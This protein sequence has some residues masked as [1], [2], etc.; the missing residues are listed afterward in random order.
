MS[1]IADK[2]PAENPPCKV[3]V[4]VKKVM[5]KIVLQPENANPIVKIP[6]PIVPKM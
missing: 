2:G 5:A 3:V 4:I 1:I 6:T